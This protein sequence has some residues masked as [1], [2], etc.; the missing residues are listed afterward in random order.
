MSELKIDG[1]GEKL[2][3]VVF[4]FLGFRPMLFCVVSLSV[5]T[6]RTIDQLCIS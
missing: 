5:S 3:D 2:F 4:Y 6:F 1:F